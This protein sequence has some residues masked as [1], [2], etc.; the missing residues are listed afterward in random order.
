MFEKIAKN[1]VKSNPKEIEV[2]TCDVE[3]SFLPL[4]GSFSIPAKWT[5]GTLNHV[6][7]QSY[8]FFL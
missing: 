1:V 4:E 3:N 7:N 2:L 5:L 8:L 6:T